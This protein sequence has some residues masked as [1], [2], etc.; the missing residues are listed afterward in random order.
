MKG[1]SNTIRDIY[2]IFDLNDLELFV[3]LLISSFSL[4][5]LFRIFGVLRKKNCP[6]CGGR[7]HRRP[8]QFNDH[9]L[10]ALTLY[11]LPFRRYKCKQCGWEGSRWNLDKEAHKGPRP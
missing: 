11:I 2:R 3:L 7:L 8:R 1:S 5:V 4:L 9:L 10:K 6:Q